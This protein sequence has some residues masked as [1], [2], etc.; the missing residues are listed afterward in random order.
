MK[1]FIDNGHGEDTPGKRSP[2]GRLREYLW[3]RQVADL[4]VEGLRKRG[5]EASLLVPEAGD[6]SLAERVFRV[7]SECIHEGDFNVL[8]VSIHVNAAG[9][10]ANWMSARGWSAYTCKGQTRSDLLAECLYDAAERE[11]DGL[12]IRKDMTDG[13]RDMEED[14][15]ILKR[16]K[17]PAVLTENFFMDNRE[18]CDFLLSDEGKRRCASVHVEGIISYL[19]MG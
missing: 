15:Y 18:D 10:G 2:D 12:K 1:I 16:S 9:N 5:W 8:L 17:C 19:C 13:D 7:N 4:V 3:N 14:F 11:F 6:I